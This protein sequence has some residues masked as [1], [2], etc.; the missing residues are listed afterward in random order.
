MIFILLSQPQSRVARAN[1][2]NEDL[3]P[4]KTSAQYVREM[5]KTEVGGS[6][7]FIAAYEAPVSDQSDEEMKI[8][9][10]NSRWRRCS[11]SSIV[12]PLVAKLSDSTIDEIDFNLSSGAESRLNQDNNREEEFARGTFATSFT[13]TS[14]LIDTDNPYNEESIQSFISH[15]NPPL[16]KYPGYQEIK[17]Q[18]M[19]AFKIGSNI[20][21]GMLGNFSFCFV[22]TND[23]ICICFK[24]MK[25]FVVK[26][27]LGEGAYAKA[28]HLSHVDRGLENKKDCVVKVWFKISGCFV[29]QGN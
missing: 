10:S 7:D 4:E 29:Q 3:Q 22:V 6:H 14:I 1:D 21:L 20:N 11:V 5:F 17:Q 27:I 8:S 13:D 2:C 19:P 25:K 18:R 23:V 12:P 15:L 26:K 16:S 24:G 9:K 28:Y